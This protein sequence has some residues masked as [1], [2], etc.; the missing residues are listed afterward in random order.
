[1]AEDSLA[2]LRS[3]TFN[4]GTLRGNGLLES[5]LAFGLTGVIEPGNS[6][7][8]LTI[9]GQ[10]YIC[11]IFWRGRGC[12]GRLEERGWANLAST[13]FSRNEAISGACR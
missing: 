6:I 8:E 13:I 4:Q 7:G 12:R 11:T 9:D 5:V 2:T 10:I 3:Q 1:M